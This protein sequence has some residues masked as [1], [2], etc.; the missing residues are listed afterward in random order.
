MERRRGVHRRPSI[1]EEAGAQFT[2]G[3]FSRR[4]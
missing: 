4:G 2:A 1:F 3:N